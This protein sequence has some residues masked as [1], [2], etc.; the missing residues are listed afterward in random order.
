MKLKL[1]T[2]VLLVLLLAF[3]YNLL[4]NENKII[5]F[6][7]TPENIMQEI[8]VKENARTVLHFIFNDKKKTKIFLDGTESGSEKWLKLYPIFRSESDAM[9]TTV[10]DMG[11]GYSLKNNPEVALK[12]IYEGGGK[13]ARICG[14]T[15]EDWTE[16]ELTIKIIKS[17]LKEVNLRIKAG[18]S[19]SADY[20]YQNILK[21]CKE[22]LKKGKIFWENELKKFS[23][24]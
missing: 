12:M 16:D 10:L 4:G 18:D 17:A 19:L 8:V 22:A 24:K 1:V 6:P 20:N 9:F 13:A 3:P 2:L 15:R 11:L 21:E 7:F 14:T 23:K 5:I